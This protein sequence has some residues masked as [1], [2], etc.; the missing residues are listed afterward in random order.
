VGDDLF[1]EGEANAGGGA[2]YEH[3]FI[4]KGHF[5]DGSQ[6]ADLRCGMGME[7]RGLAR[8]GDG[9]CL[10][11]LAPGRYGPWCDEQTCF[12][13]GIT[14]AIICRVT[15]RCRRVPIPAHH[16]WT[17][18]RAAFECFASR[19]ADGGSPT[20]ETFMSLVR[21]DV[22]I[23][24]LQPAPGAKTS[25]GPSTYPSTC[26]GLGAQHCNPPSLAAS[27]QCRHSNDFKRKMGKNSTMRLMV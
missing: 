19:T 2:G 17:L 4:R 21:T 1:S 13:R 8:V 26:T 11:G 3:A 25:S 23:S 9:S 18:H 27:G 24:V 16:L 10:L 6:R 20:M 22:V 15:R 12:E 5:D 14:S 7:W